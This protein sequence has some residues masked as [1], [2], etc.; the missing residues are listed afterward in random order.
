MN[1]FIR[2]APFFI[3]SFLFLS[4]CSVNKLAIKT[5]GSIIE[6]GMDALME[7]S[8]LVFAKESAPANLILLEGLIKGDPENSKLLISASRGFSSYTLAFIEDEDKERASLFYNRGKEY[9]LRILLKN[10]QFNEVFKKDIEIFKKSLQTFKKD[11]VPS[12]FWTGFAWGN[13][14]NLNLD[15]PE[16]L[17]DLPKVESIMNRVMEL[18]ESYYYGS[19][20]LFFGVS[21]GFR[22][23]MLGGNLEKSKEH[24]DKV[25]KISGGKF[26]IGYFYKAKYYAVSVQDKELF[27]SLLNKVISSPSDILPEQRLVNEV[28]KE[29]AK[30]LLAKMDE[31]F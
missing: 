30:V 25:I 22:S 12:L 6:Y 13:W 3:L 15:M 23:A 8:D 4:G 21:Y 28:A 2:K 26:L 11:D 14:I 29:K 10:K 19:V 20:H 24:F 7:E 9:G 27:E 5:T 18:D 16:A 31:Y 17:I 1:L